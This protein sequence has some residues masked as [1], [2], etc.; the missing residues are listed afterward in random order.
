MDSARDGAI[1]RGWIHQINVSRG[2]VPKF[3]VASAIV[4]ADGLVGDGHDDEQNHGGPQRAVC[5]FTLEEIERLAAEGNP[6]YP[7]AVGEN[8]TLRG[9]PLE[10]LTPGARVALG[11]ETLLEITSYA[12]P[13]K[14]IAGAFS[15]GD[16]TRISPKTHPG[17][18]RAYARVMRGGE[19]HE[20]D[21]VFL[22]W[23]DE[24]ETPQ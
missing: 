3:P 19:I 18:S 8:I 17:E 2:G 24:A 22:W 14:T 6:M 15:T 9:I 20:G 12:I 21:E 23:A 16:F 4:N 1:A 7:G 13:C 10:L 5:L 11:V